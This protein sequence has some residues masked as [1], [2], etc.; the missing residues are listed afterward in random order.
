V[1]SVTLNSCKVIRGNGLLLWRY[2]RSG[3]YKSEEEIIPRE[4][5]IGQVEP[6][7]MWNYWEK[8][9][10][11]IWILSERDYTG[12]DILL[13]YHRDAREK[14]TSA[15]YLYN[16]NPEILVTTINSFL[17]ASV[18]V[19]AIASKS[20]SS[21]IYM[22]RFGTAATVNVVETGTLSDAENGDKLFL[23]W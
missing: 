14:I 20:P 11:H 18:S 17:I 6:S 9:R 22:H 21:Q 7:R 12:Q 8:G 4:N 23:C 13:N 10:N 2:D 3:G 19:D 15:N 16:L 1:L 5:M